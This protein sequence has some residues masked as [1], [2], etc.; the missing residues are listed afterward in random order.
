MPKKNM[1]FILSKVLRLSL[2]ESTTGE[3]FYD[4]LLPRMTA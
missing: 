3:V 4:L 1:L 2:T